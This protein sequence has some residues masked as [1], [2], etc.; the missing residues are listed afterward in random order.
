MTIVGAVGSHL[1]NLTR[2]ALHVAGLQPFKVDAS[3][4][5]TFFDSLRSA[6][7]IAGTEGVPVVVVLTARY[8]IQLVTLFPIN[9]LY[10]FQRAV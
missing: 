8:A 10:S 7:R 9:F 4:P 1:S 2:L 6:V 3:R 5:A